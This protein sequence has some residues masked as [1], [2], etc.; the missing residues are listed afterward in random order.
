MGTRGRSLPPHQRVPRPGAC[1]LHREEKREEAGE[2]G[3]AKGCTGEMGKGGGRM[4]RGAGNKAE[5][6]FRPDLS[7]PMGATPWGQSTTEDCRWRGRGGGRA[8]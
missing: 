5:H 3:G 4:E 6:G 8:W 2:G 7:T 1:P